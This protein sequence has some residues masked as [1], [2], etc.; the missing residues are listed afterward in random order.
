VTSIVVR[1]EADAWQALSRLARDIS[2]VTALRFE[3]WPRLS[4]TAHERIDVVKSSRAISVLQELAER[5]LC[6]IKYGVADLRRLTA[7]DK[8]E[9]KLDARFE[10]SE[11]RLVIDFSGPATAAA[12]AALHPRQSTAAYGW[13][14]EG[15]RPRIAEPRTNSKREENWPR[16]AREIGLAS[17]R[18]MPPKWVQGT[19]L[20]AILVGSLA[21]ASPTMWRDKLSHVLEMQKEANA[22]QL[23]LLE[24]DR[25]KF[26]A[27]NGEPIVGDAGRTLEQDWESESWRTRMIASFESSDP[28]Y[29]FVVRQV[30]KSRPA[31]LDLAPQAGS[32]DINGLRLASNT[33]RAAATNGRR[34]SRAISAISDG[35]EATV[36]PTKTIGS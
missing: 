34:N 17:V 23:R 6:L 36:Q 29:R 20:A 4:V 32:F 31:I 10:A 19:L 18:K 27:L 8:A 25:T 2:S 14:F 5:Q 9:A 15:S 28:M 3:G 12:R 30:D 21:Y 13:N 11:T 24:L 1:N 22:H 16:T 26:S 35:W 33:A 7:R